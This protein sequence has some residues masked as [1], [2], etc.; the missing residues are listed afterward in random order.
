[1]LIISGNMRWSVEILFVEM[2]AWMRMGPPNGVQ[3]MQCD[4]DDAIDFPISWLVLFIRS[5]V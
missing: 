5:F 1:M 2:R 3:R 4:L